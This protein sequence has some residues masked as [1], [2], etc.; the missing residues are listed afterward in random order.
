MCNRCNNGSN[1]FYN[2]NNWNGWEN[3]NHWNTRGCG[4]GCSAND[5]FGEVERIA[6][7]ARRR[8]NCENRAA[9]EFVRNMR[10]CQQ[11]HWGSWNGGELDFLI[12]GGCEILT[13]LYLVNTFSISTTY[14]Q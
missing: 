1:F 4:C 13:A 2:G 3:W 7:Q 5:P 10:N 9:C 12:K 8:R 6:R 11:H 14:T